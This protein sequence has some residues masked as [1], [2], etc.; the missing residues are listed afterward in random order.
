M[1][2][3][4]A[5]LERITAEQGEAQEVEWL[6]SLRMSLTLSRCAEELAGHTSE[7]ESSLSRL[8]RWALAPVPLHQCTSVCT[9]AGITCLGVRTYQL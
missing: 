3:L 5:Y 8:L 1:G 6:L 2:A 7:L 9:V 4:R